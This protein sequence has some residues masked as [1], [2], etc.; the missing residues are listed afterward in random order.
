VRPR[1]S[2]DEALRR[3]RRD[4]EAVVVLYDRHVARLVAAL[5][6]LSGDRE[7]AFDLAQETFARLLERG[8]RVRLPAGGSVWPWLW[9]VARNLFRDYQRRNLVDAA[10]RSRLQIPAVPYDE[11]AVEDLI[12]RVDAE[13]R[14]PELVAALD[15]LPQDQR[16]ALLARVVTGDDYEGLAQRTGA[17]EQALRARVSRGLRAIRIRV[18]GGGA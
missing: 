2:D 18:S 13:Q 9:T 11:Q 14:R 16:Q 8:H 5:V 12:A 7:V 17:S 1:L 15:G 10:A 3:L 4:P 6:A